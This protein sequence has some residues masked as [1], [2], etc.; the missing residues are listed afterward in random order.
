[1]AIPCPIVPAPMTA[2]LSIKYV[3]FGPL[4]AFFIF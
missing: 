2:I 3:I 1:M 4:Y